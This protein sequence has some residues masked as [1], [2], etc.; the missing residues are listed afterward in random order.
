MNLDLEKSL[1]LEVALVCLGILPS[2]PHLDDLST[3]MSFQMQTGM[4]SPW[5]VD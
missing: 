4:S 1:Q 2:C 3:Y 5:T